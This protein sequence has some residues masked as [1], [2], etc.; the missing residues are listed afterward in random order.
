[1]IPRRALLGS[2]QIF[3]YIYNR[4][5]YLYK[6]KFQ[7]ENKLS[8]LHTFSLTD[9][10]TGEILDA[11]PINKKQRKHKENSREIDMQLTMNFEEEK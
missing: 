2:I 5:A 8:E 7:I 9:A 1:M 6:D 4:S 11:K 3:W 10:E